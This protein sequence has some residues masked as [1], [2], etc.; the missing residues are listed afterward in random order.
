MTTV[1]ISVRAVDD[2]LTQASWSEYI[3]AVNGEI[4]A[5]ADITHGSWV[6]CPV[7]PWRGACWFVEL[8]EAAEA[9]LRGRLIGLAWQHRQAHVVW[10]PARVSLLGAVPPPVLVTR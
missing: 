3:L 4:R 10:A 5:V 6:S 1:F 7:D 9:A 2:G 8:A